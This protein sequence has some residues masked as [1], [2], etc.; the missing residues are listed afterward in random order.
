VD[1][2]I[3]VEA[4]ATRALRR[5]VLV[6]TARHFALDGRARPFVRLSFAAHDGGLLREGVRHLARA[7]EA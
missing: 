5:G 7:L 2:S 6:R 3:D 4:W 1:P